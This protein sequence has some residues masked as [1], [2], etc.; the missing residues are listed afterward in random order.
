MDKSAI[1]Q[2]IEHTNLKPDATVDDIIKL[3]R[4]AKQY[5]F[6]GVCVN[7]QY[8]KLAKQHL[9]ASQCKVVT[10]VGF[11]LGAMSSEA[12]ATEA[13]IAVDAGADEIDMV[14][15]IGLLK[16]EKYEDVKEDIKKVVEAA[17]SKPVKVII[18]TVLLTE[19]EKRKACELAQEAGASFVKTSTGFSKGGATIEDVKLMRKFVAKKM[20]I[21]AA[22]GIRDLQTAKAM[23]EAGADRLGCSASVDIVTVKSSKEEKTKIMDDHMKRIVLDYAWKWFEYHASQRLIAFRFYMII[24]GA[25][26]WIF[27]RGGFPIKHPIPLG[28]SLI[29]VSIFFYILEERNN[30]LVDRGR[31]ALDEFEDNNWLVDTAYAIR[32]NDGMSKKSN[33]KRFISKFFNRYIVSHY[34]VIR[35]IYVIMIGIGLWL[36]R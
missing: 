25:L 26:G 4:E 15:S 35:A 5:Q 17:A 16:S 32:H 31:D 36:C 24:V 23:L 12:K 3:C 27:L 30:R 6:F 20:G 9:C 29:L 10:V 19:D 11:P 34:F 1:A 22:G 8:T 7:S 33:K 21:K 18:E 2:K 13:K 28:I 14:I